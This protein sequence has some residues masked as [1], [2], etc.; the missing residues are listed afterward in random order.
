M[1]RSSVHRVESQHGVQRTSAWASAVVAA[2]STLVYAVVILQEGDDSFWDVFPWAMIMLIG[3]SAALAAA[4]L[5]D[6]TVSRFFA[7]A[8]AVILGVV[9][10]VAILSIGVG[11]ILAAGLASLAAAK[12]SLAA[13]AR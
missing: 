13:G 9:G 12:S 1:Y 4:L 2:L 7:I 6:P 3:T 8:A 5:P 10:V 11:F